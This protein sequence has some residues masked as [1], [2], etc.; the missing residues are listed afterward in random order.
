MDGVEVT[1]GTGIPSGVT[2]YHVYH[3]RYCPGPSE[4]SAEA[5]V[6]L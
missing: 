3:L 5:E 2:V 1:F 4:V 6:Q